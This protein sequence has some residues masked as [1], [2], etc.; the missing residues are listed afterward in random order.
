MQ[1]ERGPVLINRESTPIVVA[2][3]AVMATAGTNAR[4]AVADGDD[5]G[6]GG[7]RRPLAVMAAALWDIV[8]C[9]AEMWCMMI[10]WVQLAMGG[11][12]LRR[13]SVALYRRRV[14]FT[15]T[16]FMCFVPVDGQTCPWTCRCSLT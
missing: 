4:E 1:A 5:I 10:D 16:C 6:D 13:S 9:I 12:G 14:D 15:E 2:V 3:G 11:G 8:G 7:R